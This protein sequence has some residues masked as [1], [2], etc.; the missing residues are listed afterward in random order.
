[1]ARKMITC[2]A[3][4][5]YIV[6]NEDEGRCENYIGTQYDKPFRGRA[7]ACTMFIPTKEPKRCPT[8]NQIIR[9]K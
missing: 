7:A 9:N 8:C 1:M 5:H 4:E 3:C 6:L 2:D